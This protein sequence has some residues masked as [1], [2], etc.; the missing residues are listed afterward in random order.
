MDFPG[1]K[2]R[3]GRKGRKDGRSVGGSRRRSCSR[4]APT[5][6]KGKVGTDA[7]L[8]TSKSRSRSIDWSH[9]ISYSFFSAAPPPVRSR[10]GASARWRRETGSAR[11]PPPPPLSRVALSHWLRPSMRSDALPIRLSPIARHAPPSRVVLCVASIE[12]VLLAWPGRQS[13]SRG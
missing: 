1:G 11:T 4:P 10:S 3:G 9:C 5:F 13:T 6:P 8:F 7:Q 2:E 12:L